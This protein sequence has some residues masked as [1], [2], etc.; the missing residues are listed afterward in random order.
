[1][2]FPSREKEKI[3][4]F[5]ENIKIIYKNFGT[6]NKKCKRKRMIMSFLP[7]MHFFAKNA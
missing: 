4:S 6:I 2:H 5:F 1:M 7:K 3:L